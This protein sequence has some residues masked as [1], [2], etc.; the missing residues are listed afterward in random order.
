MSIIFIII[1]CVVIT[2]WMNTLYLMFIVYDKNGFDIYGYNSL[3]IHMSGLTREQIQDIECVYNIK[4]YNEETDKIIFKYEYSRLYH[5][6]K[7]LPFATLCLF[8]K[9]LN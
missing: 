1:V 5:I 4:I 7:Y 9:F 8:A 6:P 2:L 3:D